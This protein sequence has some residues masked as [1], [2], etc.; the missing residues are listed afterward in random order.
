MRS[1]IKNKKGDLPSLYYAIVFLGAT[2]IMFVMVIFLA[3]SIYQTF[4]DIF[5]A[6]NRFND[7]EA[8]HFVNQVN[9]TGQQSDWDYAFLFLIVGYLI[10]LALISF[11]TFVSPVFYWIYGF[12]S[13]FG[14]L[15][16]VLFSNIWEKMALDPTL[17]PTIT[18]SFPITNTI[19][20]VLFP[21]YVT[22]M[23]VTVLVM[24]FGKG[25]LS[26]QR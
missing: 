17:S 4:D 3:N 16:A 22:V 24:L 12:L 6:N 11:S 2:A 23:I 10:V 25:P 13:I 15:L 8:H 21:T 7:T 5:T 19:M 20:G 9:E 26:N 14:L 1:I 18:Q